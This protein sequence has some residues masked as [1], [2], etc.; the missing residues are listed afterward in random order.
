[1]LPGFE[2]VDVLTD[3][4]SPRVLSA[5]P[6]CK[7][8]SEEI[9]QLV[10]PNTPLAISPVVVSALKA[11]R[12]KDSGMPI[13]FNVASETKRLAATNLSLADSAVSVAD[14]SSVA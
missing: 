10:V 3:L 14:L 13:L 6:R 2:T 9:F 7:V 12:L 8:P 1:M 11:E 4:L 5:V